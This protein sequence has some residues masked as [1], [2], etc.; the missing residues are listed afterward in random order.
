MKI[1][2]FEKHFCLI[3]GFFVT[4]LFILHTT[5][6]S[7]FLPPAHPPIFPQNPPP[8]TFQK[9]EG[10][11][12]GVNKTC[13]IKLQQVQTPLL[14]IRT[15]QGIYHKWMYSKKPIQA[16]GI[17]HGPSARGPQTHQALQLLHTCVLSSSFSLI[18]PPQLLSR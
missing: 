3:L 8:S 4:F 1:S 2:C 18:Q 14:W 13:H 6:S 9:E 12:W 10:L 11:P 16:L 7:T 15:E 17:N 5:H